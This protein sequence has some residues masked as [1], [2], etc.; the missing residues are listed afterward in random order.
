MSTFSTPFFLN[1]FVDQI[2]LPIFAI[3]KAKQLVP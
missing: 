2:Y 1:L 3:A